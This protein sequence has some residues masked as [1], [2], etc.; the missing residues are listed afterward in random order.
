MPIYK[1]LG[2]MTFQRCVKNSREFQ[3]FTIESCKRDLLVTLIYSFLFSIKIFPFPVDVG[4]L[5]NRVKSCVPWLCGD[6]LLVVDLL[7]F[8]FVV[9]SSTWCVPL[10]FDR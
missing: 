2:G 6:C 1:P 3:N 4:T 5:S 8:R 9:E 10:L 7:R